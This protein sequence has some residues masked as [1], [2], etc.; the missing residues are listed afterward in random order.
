[1]KPICGATAA[2]TPRLWRHRYSIPKEGWQAG[3]GSQESSDSLHDADVE[4]KISL[5]V[6]AFWCRNKTQKCQE[7]HKDVLLFPRCGCEPDSGGT[8]EELPTRMW[9]AWGH[10]QPAS[11][12][13][14]QGTQCR[15]WGRASLQYI[16]TSPFPL[17]RALSSQRRAG[18][19]SDI[20]VLSFSLHLLCLKSLQ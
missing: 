8:G 2:A 15:Q 13:H 12:R 19:N 6:G 18:I 1:M 9:G 16:Y 3:Q 17:T 14:T 4:L 20:R 10:G 7:Q 5:R 11:L